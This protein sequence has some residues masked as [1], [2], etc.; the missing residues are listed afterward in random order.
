MKAILLAGAFAAST[1]F[2]AY[3]AGTQLSQA[4][5]DSLWNQAN[6]SG[7]ASITQAQAQPYVTNFK[8]ANPDGD[9]SLDRNEFS[10]A[11]KSGLVK[12]TSNTGAATGEPTR[13]WPPPRRWLPAT[14]TKPCS[15]ARSTARLDCSKRAVARK[16]RQHLASARRCRPQPTLGN[17]SLR[18]TDSRCVVGVSGADG[19]VSWGTAGPM[20]VS[21]T[22]VGSDAKK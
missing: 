17:R 7:A 2:G 9:S 18:R 8:A 3:A 1:T 20:P 5:C 22:L 10:A 21:A 15:R 11:C 19:S 14:S 16:R 4:E 12:G 13:K 6:P